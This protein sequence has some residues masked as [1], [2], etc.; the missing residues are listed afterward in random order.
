MLLPTGSTRCASG[1]FQVEVKVVL[2]HALRQR[3]APKIRPRNVCDKRVSRSNGLD[4]RTVDCVSCEPQ[5]LRP[6]T[7]CATMLEALGLC[8]CTFGR[9]AGAAK[10]LRAQGWRENRISGRANYDLSVPVTSV[11]LAWSPVGRFSVAAMRQRILE[12]LL[13]RS[14]RMAATGE[15]RYA[16]SRLVNAG[17]ID[18]RADR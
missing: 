12:L 2:P 1:A 8:E 15:G 13:L 18:P 9:A 16:T 4:R 5:A 14:R 3:A 11:R 6:L 7:R 10:L 17:S